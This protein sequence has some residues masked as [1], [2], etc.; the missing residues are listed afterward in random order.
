M[1][2]NNKIESEYVVAIEKSITEGK[3]FGYNPTGFKLMVAKNG[4]VGATQILLRTLA[5]QDGFTTLV[6]SGRIDLTIEYIVAN[7]PQFH[8]LFTPEEVNIA[9]LKVE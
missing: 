4:Y 3:K 5:I 2:K 8:A 6:T 9:K 7:N 1:D